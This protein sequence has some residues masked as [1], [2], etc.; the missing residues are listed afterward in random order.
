MKEIH[1]NGQIFI[2]KV[3]NFHRILLLQ[4]DGLYIDLINRIIEATYSFGD[5]ISFQYWL[6]TKPL[7]H[8]E[9]ISQ[10]LAKVFGHVNAEYDSYSSGGCP[11]CGPSTEY[12]TTFMIGRH[13]M[14][15]I[16]QAEKTKFLFIE[17]TFKTQLS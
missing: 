3:N 6:S 11:T 7:S 5:A 12:D 9:C 17:M 10:Q 14:F 1:F 13:D 15:K 8:E 4:E 16:F 2:E